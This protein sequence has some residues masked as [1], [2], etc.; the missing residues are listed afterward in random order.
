[1]NKS[2]RRILSVAAI[3]LLVSEYTLE[4]YKPESHSYLF[5]SILSKYCDLNYIDIFEGI[6]SNI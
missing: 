1:M 3:T 4:I 6:L 5:E 2:M